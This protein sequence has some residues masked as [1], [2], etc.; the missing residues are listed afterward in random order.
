MRQFEKLGVRVA[1]SRRGSRASI[2]VVLAVLAA[3]LVGTTGASAGPAV[4]QTTVFAYEGMN[5]CTA[6]PITGTGTL[7]FLL[8]ENLSTS[9]TLQSHLE[10]RLDGLQAVGVLT[11]KKYV[12]QDTFDDE[13]V[14]GGASE[15]TFDV[16]VHYVR[17]G[18][19]GTLV[20]GDDFYEY[21]RTHI[22]ANDNGVVT[23]S[24]VDVNP[25]P[26]Q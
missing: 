23:A 22:T 6:E 19:D 21:M 25:M 15:E 12:V 8:S 24:R 2:L 26:C 17:V 1:L 18:E 11:G 9:G 14:F 16:V 13:F 5:P 10:T 4:S 7:H 3:G 20:L